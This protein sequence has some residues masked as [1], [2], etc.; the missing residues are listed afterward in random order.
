MLQI[1]RK[2]FLITNVFGFA[3]ISDQCS[4]PDGVEYSFDP[5]YVRPKFIFAPENF[6]SEAKNG[7]YVGVKYIK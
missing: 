2:W 7:S 4:N 1:S 6:I 5:I 3:A